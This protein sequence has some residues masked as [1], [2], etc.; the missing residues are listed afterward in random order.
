[1]I[2]DL[3]AD[4]L[5]SVGFGLVGIAVLAIGY[6]AIDLLTPGKLGDL[7]FVQ[8][9]LNASIVLGSGLLALGAVVATGIWTA[10]GDRGVGIAQSAGYGVLGVVLLSGAFLLIDVVTPGK[11]GAI[12]TEDRFHPASLITASSHLAMGAVVAASIT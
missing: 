12:V 1:M 3:P 11:L 5:A 9:N 10:E 7:I 4:L 8:R 2:S 6:V